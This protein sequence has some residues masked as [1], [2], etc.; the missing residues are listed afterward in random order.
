MLKSNVFW[1][2]KNVEFWLKINKPKVE[3]MQNNSLPTKEI[4]ISSPI[5]K[6]GASSKLDKRINDLSIILIS[7]WLKIDF[8]KTIYK[9]KDFKII[10]VLILQIFCGKSNIVVWKFHGSFKEI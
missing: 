9:G 6:I 7:N 8:L 5:L 2:E 4:F 10:L 1:K 3:G